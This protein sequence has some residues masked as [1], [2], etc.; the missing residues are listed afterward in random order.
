MFDIRILRSVGLLLAILSL[1]L[2][3]GLRAA[4]DSQGGQEPQTY[5]VQPGDSLWTIAEHTS[6]GDPRDAVGKIKELNHL[7]SSTIQA[8]QALLLPAF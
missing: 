5:I 3:I 6:T 2:V 7:D 8:G 4:P 1:V